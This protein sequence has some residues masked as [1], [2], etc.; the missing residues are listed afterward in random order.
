[1]NIVDIINKKRLKEELTKEELEFAVN[2]YIDNSIKDYQMSSL[3]MAICLNG[4]SDDEIYYLTDI[5]LKSGDTVDLSFINKVKVDKHSTGGVGDKTSLILLPL[6]AA[7]GVVAP[8]MSGR[9]LGFTGGT[10]DK[11]EAIPG[12][13]S[14]LSV[15]EFKREIEEIGVSDISQSENLVPADKKLYSLRDVTGTVESLPLIASSIM[16][17]K[18]AS[19]ADKIVID[20]KVG[21]GALIKNI[22]DAR[23][24]AS[25]MINIG[26]KYNKEVRCILTDMNQ[27]LGNMIGNSL[28]VKEAIDVLK[29]NGPKD[30]T[31][32]VIV[33]ASTMV[34]MGLNISLEE[35][36]KLVLDK[37]ND[38]SAFNKFLDL[39]RYQGGNL[40]DM[41]I[42]DK[43]ISVKSNKTGF[44]SKIKT[45]ELGEV[46]RKLGGGRYEK[47]DS[48][49]PSVGIEL[50][51]KQGDYVLE[52]EELLKVY[53]N[54]KDVPLSE[55]LDCFIISNESG[56]SNPLIYEIICS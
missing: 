54:E 16:S 49:D 38:G 34:Q 48:I 17:K 3:L 26:K 2:G 6:V 41:V 22:D 24:L 40:E 42:S 15:E 25:I 52:D 33:L 10:I 37:L 47:E 7:C 46:V 18:L 4:M 39:V 5:M 31:D 11:L 13:K 36:N 12:F 53:M 30:I 20:L 44:V 9:G 1:M 50:V 45:N 55:I 8:K 23:R 19:G 35:A 14:N 27:P 21:D 32:L 28:E 43:V 29:G 56:E 51:V